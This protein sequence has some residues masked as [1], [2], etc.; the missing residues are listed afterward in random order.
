M[1]I[2]QLKENEVAIVECFSTVDQLIKDRL[3]QLGIYPNQEICLL[4]KLP[5][6][7]PCIIG[8]CGQCICIRL[9]DA[10]GI[11]VKKK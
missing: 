10:K 11:E 3:M 2:A 6:G 8:T 1:N 5:F 4:R 9:Y 7:G